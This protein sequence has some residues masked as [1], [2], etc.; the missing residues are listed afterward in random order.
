MVLK[1]NKG[2]ISTIVLYSLFILL[3]S[4]LFF[5]LNTYKS[6]RLV[7]EREIIEIKKKL[8]TNFQ[9]TVIET[10]PLLKDKILT[11]EGGVAAII[12][13][14]TPNFSV[15]VTNRAGMYATPD[16]L[17]TSYYYRGYVEDNYVL[18]NNILWRVVRIDGSGNIK[19]MFYN[20]TITATTYRY[21]GIG[22]SPFNSNHRGTTY[23]NFNTSAIKNTLNNWYNSRM[24]NVSS[25]L[26]S[27][28]YCIDLRVTRT[29]DLNKYGCYQ[30]LIATN[31][32]P[33]LTCSTGGGLYSYN[34]NV[35]LLSAD[36]LV[37]AGGGKGDNRSFYLYSPTSYW[38]LSAGFNKNNLSYGLATGVGHFGHDVVVISDG[39]YPTI[40]IKSTLR[41]KSG[42][43]TRTDPY[44][45]LGL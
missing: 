26:T 5:V 15:V 32:A 19:L 44:T 20:D 12:R 36:E 45:I 29:N 9:D 30:R 33:T 34:Y 4:I 23:S 3:L 11:K 18:F 22:A 31:S 28:K 38:L 13:K 1:N 6:N 43:G 10:F 2:F 42:S 35:G 25:Y 40:S 7:V 37:F 17:G 16:N 24:S 39:V 21:F 8:D 41:C 14:G 27:G